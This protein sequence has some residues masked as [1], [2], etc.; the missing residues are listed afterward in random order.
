MQKTLRHSVVSEACDVGHRYLRPVC[1]PA[2]A[3]NKFDLIWDA[4]ADV[5]LA[6]L[7]VFASSSC[8]FPQLM[9]DLHRGMNCPVVGCT[10]AGEISQEGFVQDHVIAIGL[11]AQWFSARS[12]LVEDL[13]DISYPDLNDRLIQNRLALTTTNR[14]KPNGFSFLMVDGLSRR[15][16]QLAS[17]IAPSLAGF[18][19]FG[20]SAGDGLRFE[21]SLVA[22]EGKVYENA[23]TLTYVVTNCEVEVFSLNHMSPGRKQMVVTKAEPN[24]RVVCG[25]NDE[26]AAAEY[27]RLIGKDPNQLDEFT[28]AEN[29]VTVRVGD[30]YH[31]RAIQ[32]VNEDGN[33]VFFSAIDEGMVLTVAE[34]LDMADSLDA[35]LTKIVNGHGRAEILACDCILRRIEA[36][37]SQ[38][39]H[40]V[41]RVFRDHGVVGFSTYGEQIGP[42]HVN[43]TLTGV[44]LFAPKHAD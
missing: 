21:R 25:I 15:E 28:F 11:P 30:D 16:D 29:P 18:P 43:H 14:S 9:S 23:A 38:N 13:S 10:S 34:P 36:E 5:N 12:M 19:L 39:T 1:V 2:D 33:L 26:P 6:H 8:D 42:L 20:G 7:F 4:F 24:S 3:A 32:R 37:K 31:V 40:R 22:F 44:A 27:A 35:S 17:A 41:N